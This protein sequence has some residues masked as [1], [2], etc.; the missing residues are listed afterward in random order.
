MV[1]IPDIPVSKNKFLTLFFLLFLFVLKSRS[2]PTSRP[3]VN[4]HPA[5]HLG[6]HVLKA[7][8]V[9]IGALV[10]TLWLEEVLLE[11]LAKVAHADDGVDDGE[12]DQEDGD[13]GESGQ[14]PAD[15]H[16]VLAVSRLVDADQLEDEVAQSTEIEDDDGDNAQLVLAAGE[17]GGADED[18]DG[19]GDGSGGEGVLDDLDVADNDEEL[20]GEA[21]EKEKV[22]LEEGNVDLHRLT[23][24]VDILGTF[25]GHRLT[26]REKKNGLLGNKGTA[27][28]SGSRRQWS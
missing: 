25:L 22:E 13:D 1:K 6:L 24:L 9:E 2:S 3:L 19:D 20:N 12:N 21:E 27:A 10:G 17:V 15:G 23:L 11:A 18:G 7:D 4:R 26:R 8:R 28:S 16:V 14:R 5:R